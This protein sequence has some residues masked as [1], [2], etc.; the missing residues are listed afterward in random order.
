[1]FGALYTALDVIGAKPEVRDNHPGPTILSFP[2]LVYWSRSAFGALG[3][4]SSALDIG[5]SLL[6]IA[7]TTRSMGDPRNVPL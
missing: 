2:S 6:G 7:F 1:V 5:A 3:N 4:P